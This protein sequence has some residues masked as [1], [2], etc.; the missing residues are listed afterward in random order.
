MRRL[1]RRNLLSGAGAAFALR[2][3]PALAR[4]QAAD[5]ALRTLLD[6][7]AQGAA[8]DEILPELAAIDATALSPSARLDLV[9]AGSGLVVD[10]ELHSR[11]PFGRLGKSPYRVTPLAG[12]WIKHSDPRAI[13]A[14]T[15]AILVDARAGVV[16]PAGLLARTIDAIQGARATADDAAAPSL[17]NQLSVLRGQLATAPTPGVGLLPQGLDYYGL[18]LRR[19]AGDD[20]NPDTAWRRLE[21]ERVRTLARADALLKKLGQ[22]TGTVGA[23]FSAL[24]SDPRWL[25]SDD[26]AG[27]DTAVADMNR[28]LDAAR[29]RLPTEFASYPDSAAAV[30]V[31][32]MS[33]EDAAAG[34]SGYRALPSATTPGSYFVDLKDIRRRP[35]W[36]LPGAVHH[37]LLP[38]HMIQLPIEAAADPHPLRLEYA[39]AFAEGWAIY[40]EQLAAADGAF[41]GDPMAELGH[42]HWTLFR[43]G[44]GL[45]DLGIH[46]HGWT[47]DQAQAKLAEWQG[48]PA[49]FAPFALELDRITAEPASRAAEALVWL[50]LADLARGRDRKAFHSLVLADGRK[51]TD[52]LRRIV[53]GTK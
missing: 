31:R 9:T 22:K 30:R 28:T 40:A 21:Q 18:L 36:T 46:L 15:A 23:R 35:T 34:R 17:D 52:E 41:A 26:D 4:P 24:W 39:P 43:I 29:D 53:A 51:R 13:D 44:R 45:A 7:A 2:V 50:T 12:A 27:R 48:E 8:P 42:L 47:L 25:Y 20:A 16:L 5:A 14:D 11:F 6:R 1:S 49:Y 33:A 3:L 37:E 38:G 32:R 10:S 19:F